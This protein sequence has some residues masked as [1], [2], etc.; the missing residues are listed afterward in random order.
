[1]ID[2]LAMQQDM[3]SEFKEMQNLQKDMKKLAEG[4]QILIEQQS[5]CEIVKKVNISSPINITQ[6]K[7]I[8]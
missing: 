6:K 2:I 8:T 5:E 3:E 4:R 1:M 7:S